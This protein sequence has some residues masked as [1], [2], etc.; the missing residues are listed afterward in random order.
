MIELERNHPWN[1]EEDVWAIKSIKSDWNSTKEKSHKEL[2]VTYQFDG[3]EEWVPYGKVLED[4]PW[5]VAQY[6]MKQSLNFQ[7]GNQNKDHVH[8]S[9]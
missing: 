1:Q 3:E 6:I 9:T 7:H 4:K 8:V 5:H 2:L